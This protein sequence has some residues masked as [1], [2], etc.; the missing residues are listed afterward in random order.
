MSGMVN[1]NV[2]RPKLDIFFSFIAQYVCLF[3]KKLYQCISICYVQWT[4]NYSVT[5]FVIHK[6]CFVLFCFSFILYYVCIDMNVFFFI[7]HNLSFFDQSSFNYYSIR[8]GHRFYNS[9]FSSK[10]IALRFFFQNPDQNL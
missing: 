3:S 8:R 4:F 1:E 2:V 7:Y 5:C 10:I 9:S 6:C